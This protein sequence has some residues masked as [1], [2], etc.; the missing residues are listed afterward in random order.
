MSTKKLKD[1]ADMTQE[2]LDL[3]DR[4]FLIDED[5]EVAKFN[6]NYY[7][8]YIKKNYN[9][10][11][12]SDGH[13]YSFD[14]GVWKQVPKFELLQFLRDELQEPRFGVWNS[15]REEE[16][17]KALMRELYLI[18]EFNE[19]R[20]LINMQNGMFDTETLELKDHNPDWYSTI[21]LPIEYDPEAKCP[22]FLT[23]LDQIFDGDKE[24]VELAQQWF[25]YCMSMETK[26]QKA[27]ILY[28]SGGN[29]KGVFTDILSQVVGE[30]N[31]AH[32]PLNEL[33]KGFS[34][35]TLYGK[36]LNLSSENEMGG[37]SMN[38][39]YFKAITG[40]DT[41]TAEQKGKPVFSF[42]PTAKIVAS[43]NNMPST[44][45]RSDGYFRRLSMIPFVKSFRGKKQDKHL[46]DKLLEELPGIFNWAVEGLVSLKEN[47]YQFVASKASEDLLES[48]R[49]EMSPMMVFF[50]ECIDHDEEGHR[51][52]NKQIYN[53]FKKWSEDNGHSGYANISNK[54]FWREFE[55]EADRLGYKWESKRTG[56]F[57]Y[58]TG[59]RIKKE[60][61]QELPKL[62]LHPDIRKEL[63]SE[64]EKQAEQGRKK[65]TEGQKTDEKSPSESK[66]NQ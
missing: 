28:G 17:L 61:R 11:Y 29:G 58:H 27:L 31:I 14:E 6:A 25:G 52:S 22:K 21:Q 16:Y 50:E 5:G 15:R 3:Y 32:V 65:A 35:V 18:G 23:F 1:K 62:R 43:T 64:D 60:F 45:D 55:A 38:T 39:Q 56:S 46:R 10:I 57:R 44:R 53:F 2:E 9:L 34:R 8:I 49:L 41:I 36:T 24:L 40:E 48:Y 63:E 66:Q 13:F 20:H 37:K 19:H 51:E 7:A 59:I 54:K 4:G 12:G 26:A 30:E 42:R 33:H 47:E